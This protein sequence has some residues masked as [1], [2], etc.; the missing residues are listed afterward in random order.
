MH[1]A[2]L[3]KAK[4][5]SSG[6]LAMASY[7]DRRLLVWNGATPGD[8]KRASG[9]STTFPARYCIMVFGSQQGGGK[10]VIGDADG[11]ANGNLA[12]PNGLVTDA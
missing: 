5:D 10:A 12:R 11:T 9:A 3:A 7:E 6:A 8:A 1:K 4:Y 2:N